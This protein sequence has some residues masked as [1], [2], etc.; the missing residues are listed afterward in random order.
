MQNISVNEFSFWLIIIIE[1]HLVS[2]PEQPPE[3]NI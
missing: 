2:N 3:K 1:I